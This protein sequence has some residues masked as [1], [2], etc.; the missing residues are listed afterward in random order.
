MSLTPLGH[1]SSMSFVLQRYFTIFLI[2]IFLSQGVFVYAQ[3]QPQGGQPT[4]EQLLEQAMI[5][6]QQMEYEQAVNYL[7]AVIQSPG[8][9]P[10][11]MARALLFLGTC[12]TALG[13]AENAVASFVSLLKVMPNFRLPEG[14]SPSV[15]AM[16]SEAL[17]KLN[18]PEKVPEGAAEQNP[19]K[20]KAQGPKKVTTGTPI[21][22][23]IEYND[24]SN[25]VQKFKIHWRRYGGADFSSVD[26]AVEPGKS[27]VKGQISG[28]TL[29]KEGKI[30]YF[31]EAV[32]PS[33]MTV[34]VAGDPN[35]PY[36]VK[37]MKPPPPK[38][39]WG[40]W[41]LGIG[42]GLAVVGGVVAAILAAS[43]GNSG[44]PPTSADVTVVIH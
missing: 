8:V 7:A 12:F 17:K 37:L 23:E 35:S 29:D 20:V 13:K 36:V 10:M 22:V 9:Q 44:N 26:V 2:I 43:G 15:K 32:G 27:K 4:P 40:W 16:F 42:G 14:Y 18:L 33:D 41:A 6:Y 11:V 21:E 19:V 31:V 24:P 25:L 3:G 1:A 28:A 38:S 5:Y 34:G 30:L 39:N